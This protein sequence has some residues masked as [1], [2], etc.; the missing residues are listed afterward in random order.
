MANG[1]TSKNEHE[2]RVNK[3]IAD[4]LKNK[5]TKLPPEVQKVKEQLA[6]FTIKSL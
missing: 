2:F 3:V 5:I 4:N 1:R 6:N